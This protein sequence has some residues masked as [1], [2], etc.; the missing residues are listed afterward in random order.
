[1]TYQTYPWASNAY[2][3][4]KY[5]FV[6]LDGCNT[7]LDDANYSSVGWW[8]SNYAQPQNVLGFKNVV[9]GPALSAG[10]DTGT[11]GDG[12]EN[13]LWADLGSGESFDT[14][15]VNATNAIGGGYGYAG[16]YLYHNPGSSTSLYPAGYS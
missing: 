1:M 6:D 9:Y 8:L 7:F 12:W 15:A 5:R 2:S 14:A 13:T 3:M 4:V 11:Y 16:W 10:P